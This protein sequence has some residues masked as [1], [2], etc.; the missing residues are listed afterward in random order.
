M[1][2]E[3]VPR[4]YASS[5]ENIRVILRMFAENRQPTLSRKVVVLGVAFLSFQ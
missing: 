4:Q 5:S 1:C 3:A 2:V